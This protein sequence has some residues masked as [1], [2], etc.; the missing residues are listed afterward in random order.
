MCQTE[1]I[2]KSVYARNNHGRKPVKFLKRVSPIHGQSID[3]NDIQTIVGLKWCLKKDRYENIVHTIA[4][5][6]LWN[7]LKTEEV[8]TP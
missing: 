5:P 1:K 4:L 8:V 3:R 2:S 7:G 6:L